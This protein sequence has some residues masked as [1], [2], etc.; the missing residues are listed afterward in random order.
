MSKPERRMTPRP[1][2]TDHALLRY[3]ERH[4]GVDVEAHRRDM[5]RA[6]ERGV[7]LGACG[8]VTMGLRFVLAECRVVTCLPASVPDVRTGRA[9]GRRGEVDG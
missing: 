7:E 4:V 2:I 5:E 3:L 1:H 8:V 9:R 6:V